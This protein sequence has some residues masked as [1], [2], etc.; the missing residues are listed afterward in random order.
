ML[1]VCPAYETSV[2]SSLTGSM[3]FAEEADAD[4]DEDGRDMDEDLVRKP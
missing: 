1:V 3:P 2:F 4:A